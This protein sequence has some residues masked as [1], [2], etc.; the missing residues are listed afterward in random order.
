MKALLIGFGVMGKNHARLLAQNSAVKKIIIVDPYIN[1]TKSQFNNLYK[2]YKT[3]THALR[4]HRPDFAIVAS[5]TSTHYEQC[6]KLL[7]HKIPFIVEKPIT[8]D[9]FLASKII[10]HAEEL[11]IQILPGHVERYNP[12]VIFL[13]NK[14]KNY[15]INSIY[16]IEVNRCSPFPPRITDLGVGFDLSVHD[17]DVLN[18]LLGCTPHS[19]FSSFSYN[20]HPN[21]EDGLVSIINYDHNIQCI[22]NT[23]WTSPLKKRELK[24]FA[25]WGL[26][27]LDFISQ[28]VEFFENP[29]AISKDGS[30]GW[31][32][33]SEG[34]R[35]RFNINKF[36]PL[37]NEHNFFLNKLGTSYKFKEQI[38]SALNAIKV[39]SAFHQSNLTKS[40]IEIE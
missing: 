3:I 25:G 17:L 32:G 36:E 1:N 39:V 30:W 2:T 8:T 12:A 38:N 24:I 11:N 6:F 26:F 14:L 19:V 13:K 15:D 10:Q 40:F 22:M 23:N 21:Y 35:I 20:I 37:K 4:N 5:P 28:E 29:S 33:I 18:Y 31:T 7:A 16:R 34:Q 9:F 27:K